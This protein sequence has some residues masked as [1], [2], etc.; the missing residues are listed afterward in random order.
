MLGKCANPECKA[1][2]R[3]LHEGRVF[4]IYVPATKAQYGG[5]IRAARMPC[6]Q[7]YWLCPDCL[8]HINI[9]YD[10]ASDRIVVHSHGTRRHPPSQSLATA[11]GEANVTEKTYQQISNR[12]AS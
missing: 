8:Q 9:E 12:I 7:Y 10:E 3:Y 5:E 2:F 11:G 4:A 1:N 6:V